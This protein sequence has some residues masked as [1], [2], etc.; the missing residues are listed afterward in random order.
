MLIDC[1]QCEM[2]R[3]EQCDDCLVTALLHPPQTNVEIEDDLYPELRTLTEAGL[4]PV[5]KFRPRQG[6]RARPPVREADTG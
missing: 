5:L 2:Y 3:T 1:S 6:G 4:I